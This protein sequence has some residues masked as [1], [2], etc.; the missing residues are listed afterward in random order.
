[1]ARAPSV[2][3]RN[4]LKPRSPGLFYLRFSQY[5]MAGTSK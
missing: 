2:R 4:K 1:M 3:K 5:F